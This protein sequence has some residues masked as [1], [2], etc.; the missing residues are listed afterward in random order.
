[1]LKDLPPLFKVN[2]LAPL[3]ANQSVSLILEKVK[4]SFNEIGILLI[5]QS[6]LL[7]L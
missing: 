1:M 6:P 2:N 3:E 7:I 5:T 4:S